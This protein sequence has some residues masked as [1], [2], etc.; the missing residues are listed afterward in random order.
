MRNLIKVGNRI[1][2]LDNVTEIFFE[3][4]AR[5]RRTNNDTY[6]LETVL[7]TGLVGERLVVSWTY[8]VDGSP[9]YTEFF[10]RE[11]RVL[12]EA[13]IRFTGAMEA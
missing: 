7:D 2:N 12:W 13:I 10:M 5:I 1:I 9:A 3:E 8:T 11:A 6:Y 4:K